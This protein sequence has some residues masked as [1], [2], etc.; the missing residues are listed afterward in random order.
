MAQG[1]GPPNP[2]RRPCR[3][4]AGKHCVPIQTWT[5]VAAPSTVCPGNSSSRTD[6]PNGPTADVGPFFHKHIGNVPDAGGREGSH[7][8]CRRCSCSRCRACAAASP[9]LYAPAAM[10]SRS[11]DADSGTLVAFTPM[12][13]ADTP[14]TSGGCGPP[15]IRPC[16]WRAYGSEQSPRRACRAACRGFRRRRPGREGAAATAH[17]V[18]GRRPRDDGRDDGTVPEAGSSHGEAARA[19]PRARR[20]GLARP[21]AGGHGRQGKTRSWRRPSQARPSPAKRAWSRS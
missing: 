6:R 14:R 13:S 19:R 15:R 4:G 2:S 17:E 8:R 9:R 21:P 3:S 20:V 16:V 11:A 1:P 5:G 7:G 10:T 18:A 12:R